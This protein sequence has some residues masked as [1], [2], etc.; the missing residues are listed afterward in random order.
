MIDYNSEI[1][2]DTEGIPIGTANSYVAQF[3]KNEEIKGGR[4]TSVQRILSE[5]ASVKP[6]IW[7]E[8]NEKDILTYFYIK[9]GDR[10]G[11]DFSKVASKIA[12][13]VNR[14]YMKDFSA[15]FI[16]SKLEKLVSVED[17]EIQIK[18]TQL[19]I[20]PQKETFNINI[21]E[22]KYDYIKGMVRLTQEQLELT[23]FLESDLL[24]FSSDENG[25]FLT[26]KTGNEEKFDALFNF[27]A[28]ETSVY[29]MFKEQLRDDFK[30]KKLVLMSRLL[31]EEEKP[32][33]K[34]KKSE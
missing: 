15:E 30:A 4:I 1:I 29:E 7:D 31:A 2:S 16:L 34:G 9:F 26:V 32:K 8:D 18:S 5:I 25:I 22:K 23:P 24:C 17:V 10:T 12:V 21:K 33:R 3:K 19:K 27:S 14:V 28:R 20:S 13:A 6:E 11:N